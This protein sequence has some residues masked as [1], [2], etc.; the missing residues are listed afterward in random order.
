MDGC[1]SIATPGSVLGGSL[2]KKNDGLPAACE[3]I[4]AALMSANA[5]SFPLATYQVSSRD[6]IAEL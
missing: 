4:E 1:A 5:V 6:R 3:L 2:M